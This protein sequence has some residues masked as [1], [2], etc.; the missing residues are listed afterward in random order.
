M[1][2]VIKGNLVDIFTDEIYPAD[3]S[4]SGGKIISVKKSKGPYS[5]YI[6][7]GLIDSH[8]HIESSMLTPSAFAELAVKHG[9]VAVVSDPHEIAN[10]IGLKGINF[11]IENG[12]SV[13]LKFFFGAPSCVPATDFECSGARIDAPDIEKLLQRDDIYFLSEMMNYPGV[14]RRDKYIIKKIG[15]A[16]KLNKPVDGHAP[17][18]IG[19]DLKKYIKEGIYTDHECI[20][21]SE[22]EEKINSGM[23]IQIREGSAAKSFNTFYKL[24]DKFPLSVMLCT[25]DIHPDDLVAG[26]I[27]FLLAKGIEKGVNIFNLLRAASLNPALHYKLPVGMLRKGDYADMVIVKDLDCFEVIET[28]INGEKVFSNNSILFQRKVKG[29]N[30]NFRTEHIL[31]RDI[32]LT[33]EGSKIKVMQV[34]NGDLYTRSRVFKTKVE[35]GYAITDTKRDICKI[36]VV[37]K[38]HS[39]KP[40]LGFITGF[41]LK[42]GAIAGSIAHDSHNIIAVGVD[43]NDILD[44]VNT[45]IDLQGGLAVASQGEIKKIKLEICGIMTNQ[46]GVKLAQEYIDLDNLAKE[47]GSHLT[48]PFMSLSFMSLLV[49]PELKIGDQG[50]FDVNKFKFT[51]VFIK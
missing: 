7:P 46:D 12:E 48:A 45:I 11:M 33:S 37:N 30:A 39:A 13:P 14:I 26:H 40:A 8:V 29:I 20:N 27:N 15:Y 4:F 6:L 9:T 31:E 2:N 41:G 36:I 49:I 28:F 22:A 34:N 32:K 25:D 19:D 47:L 42:K 17:G 50:L 10:I 3:I 18:L 43:D 44:A 24:I 38:Y 35:N 51:S 5:D 16:K 1:H 23:K 21:L